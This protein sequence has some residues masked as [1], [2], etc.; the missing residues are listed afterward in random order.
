VTNDKSQ[1][2][3][4][5]WDGLLHHKFIIQFA[6]E[7]I[8]EIGEHLAKLQ[9]KW[10]VVPNAPFAV[11]FCPQTCRTR[12]ISKIISTLRQKLLLITGAT[13]P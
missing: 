5:Y 2:T 3:V 1:G 7:R 11:H 10:L 13:F 8:F 12:Q 9:A 4:A 6:A